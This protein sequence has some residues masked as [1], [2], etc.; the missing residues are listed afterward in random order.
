MNYGKLKLDLI[1]KG[2]YIP[3]DFQNAPEICGGFHR[4]EPGEEIAL[5]LAENLIAKAVIQSDPVAGMPLLVENGAII[6]HHEDKR[7]EV[8][9]I[10]LPAF[11][12]EQLQKRTPLSENVCLDGYCLNIFIRVV[13]KDKRLSL[14]QEEV[15]PIVKSAFEE[16]VADLVQINM[17]YCDESDRGFER[18]APMVKAIKEKFKT[19]VALKGFPPVEKRT[20]DLMY[21]SGVDLLDFPLEGFA[22]SKEMQEV[23]PTHKVHAA[24]EY[25]AEVFPRG[26]VWTELVPHS[27][28]SGSTTET[29]AHL[30]SKGIIPLLKLQPASVVT[31]QEFEHLLESVQ[32]LEE[33]TQQQ[34]LPLKW[35]YPNCRTVTPLDTRY[36]TQDSETA[37][38]TDK[39]VYRSMLSKKAF[40]GFA[41]I[42]RKLRIKD[43]SD[44][45]ESA[46]L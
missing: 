44:S 32:F 23:L 10:P 17:D 2:V 40:E 20:I 14:S 11:L 41:A 5:A 18:L 21:A 9:V 1:R 33:I 19:F 8:G 27:G 22:G 38:L 45:Y 31:G 35:L 46:G 3:K 16:G 13:G 4:C 24:L 12:E 36:F 39:P 28:N 25:A 6:L 34:K 42:R 43:I 15:L 30:V 37:K 26:T 7:F 29:I